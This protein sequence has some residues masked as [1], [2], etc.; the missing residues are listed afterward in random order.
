MRWLLGLTAI[1]MAAAVWG[2]EPASPATQSLSLAS[3]VTLALEKNPSLAAAREEL[4][5]AQ[6]RLRMAQA[7]GKLTGSANATLSTGTMG[8]VIPSPESVMP[9]MYMGVPADSRFDQNLTLM[10]P[11]STGGRVGSRVRAADAQV[12]ATTQDIESMVLEVAY[13]V[14]AAY[15][16]ALYQRQ[17]VTVHE[18]NVA[19]QQERLRVDQAKYDAGKI[20]LFYVLRDKSELADAQQ[21]LTNA[22]RDAETALLDLRAAIGLEL[23]AP[24][25][26]TDKLAYD[27]AAA[28]QETDKLLADALAKRPEALALR[29]RLDAAEREVAARKAAYR[30]QVDGMVMLDAGKTSGADFMGGYT[31]GVVGSLP[32]FDGGERKASVSE[33]EAMARNLRRQKQALDLQIERELRAALLTLAAAN[34]NVRTAMEAEASAEEDHRVANIGYQAGKLINLEAVS[35]LAA[36]VKARTNVAQAI[37]EYNLT[38]DAVQRAAGGR[39][40]AQ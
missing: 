14:R 1:T 11:L 22:G 17:L 7:A 33:A 15:W 34:R 4:P 2:Q 38:A 23:T 28:D 35:A 21:Q 37:Y 18:E 26:L 40:P 31:V 3:A 12:R 25:E 36:L 6:A 32:L 27:P 29:A 5:A 10:Y 39:P 8:A 20:P 13:A 9:R 16:Q 24:V 30:P 19:E